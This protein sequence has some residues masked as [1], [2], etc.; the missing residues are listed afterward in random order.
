M[1]LRFKTPSLITLTWSL[2]LPLLP[3][4]LQSLADQERIS[5]AA[6]KKTTLDKVLQQPGVTVNGVASGN[7]KSGLSL[8]NNR[9]SGVKKKTWEQ[10]GMHMQTCYRCKGYLNCPKQLFSHRIKHWTQDSFEITFTF[11]CQI[12]CLYLRKKRAN[13]L[14][15]DAATPTTHNILYVYKYS[16]ML[17]CRELSTCVHLQIHTEEIECVYNTD[18]CAFALELQSC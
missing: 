7:G 6:I 9:S 3:R 2:L 12:V 5:P 17:W 4:E 18:V 14:G 10:R 16:L 11:I 1:L 15:D 8:F 13:R